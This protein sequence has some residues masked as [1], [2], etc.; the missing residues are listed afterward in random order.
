MGRL[1]DGR[2]G[3]ALNGKCGRKNN[4]LK[5]HRREMCS[6]LDTLCLTVW[7]FNTWRLTCWRLL[8]DQLVGQWHSLT[9]FPDYDYLARIGNVLPNLIHVQRRGKKLQEWGCHIQKGF[10]PDWVVKT[11]TW[12]VVRN[13]ISRL[14][15]QTLI[16]IYP[17]SF[18][19]VPYIKA[20]RIKMYRSVKKG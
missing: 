3:S 20:E 4:K 19:M 14:E 18:Y 17:R 12:E 13:N 7:G 9:L 6:N 11:K 8:E 5:R 16:N 1:R 2:E 10:P 15:K